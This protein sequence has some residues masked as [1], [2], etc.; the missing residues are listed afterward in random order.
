MRG[1]ALQTFKNIISPNRENLGEILNVFRRKY[2]KPQLMATTKH[3]LQ[4][5]VFNRANQKIIDFLDKLQKLAKD[6]FGVAAEAIVE[7]FINAKMPPHLKKSINQAH[8]EKNTYEQI[9]S[10]LEKELE[11]NGLETQ[12]ELQINTV[13]QQVTQQNS[14]KTR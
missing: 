10:R 3:K 7:Q 14:E 1:D 4:R 9:E 8:L 13:M 5:L 6:T 11:L 12:D 2:V